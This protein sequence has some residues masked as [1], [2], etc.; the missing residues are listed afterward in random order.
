MALMLDV[1]SGFGGAS[2]A[3]EADPAW[4]VVRYE[5]NLK[6]I[7]HP[8]TPPTEHLDITKA[9][10]WSSK[11]PKLIWCSPPCYDF[12]EAYNAPKARAMREGTLETYTPSTALVERCYE[13]IQRL[14]PHYWVIENVK[15]SIPYLSPILGRPR[16]IIGPYVLWGNFPLLSIELGKKHKAK[17][18]D[19]YRWCAFRSNRVAK[20]PMEFSHELKTALEDQRT[21]F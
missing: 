9:S 10:P 18:G 14:A 6:L 19:K 15:G 11:K 12:S 3:F 21:L 7:N 13:I 20:I 2:Q 17:V 1:C 5:N 16:Q 4:E 8:E